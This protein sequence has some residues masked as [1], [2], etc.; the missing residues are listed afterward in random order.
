MKLGIVISTQPT[1]FSA[2]RY[3][4]NLES[5]IANAAALGYDGVEL[6]VREPELLN[7]E[8]VK[9][10]LTKYS[11]EVPAIGTGQAFVEE[12]LSFSDDSTEIRK[13]AIKRIK[14]HIDLAGEL[15]TNVIIGLIRGRGSQDA[16]LNREKTVLM[17][18]GLRDCA[19]YALQ[20]NA[21]LFLEP[22]N[23]YESSL[24]NNIAEG[25]EVIEE[26]GCKNL[27]LL[28]DTFHMNIEEQSLFGSIIRAMPHTGH[29]HFA[30]S[31]RHAP[32]AGHIGF[33]EILGL[34]SQLDYDGYV[35]MEMLPLPTADRAAEISINHLREIM[36]N[37]A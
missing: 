14:S 37:I 26:Q 34:L 1:K 27:K 11:M 31:N 15:G 33:S 17:K 23:R 13:A 28:I 32:G 24:V 21:M 2:L 22:L 36:A 5:G 8:L 10:L 19:E 35:S 12:G 6:A 25:I 7:V 18:E 9:K 29:V 20:K 16:E 30:D 4:E 3:D